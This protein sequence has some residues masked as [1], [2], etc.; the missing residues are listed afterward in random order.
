MWRVLLSIF[1]VLMPLAAVAQNKPIIIT[2]V[3]R[4]PFSIVENGQN[5][6]FS[7]DLWN[8]VASEL[9]RETNFRQADSFTDML[10]QVVDGRV[11]GAI[12]NI[13]ITAERETVM[14]F[15]QPIF[16]SGLQIMLPNDTAGTSVFST[17]FTWDIAFAILIAIAM[18]FGG[19]ML[20]WAFERHKQVYFD[21]DLKDAT[22][23]AFWWAL[24]LVV[25]GG[26]EERMPMS[27]PGRVLSVIM[28][29]ASL[30]LV[31]VFVAKITAAMTVDA[32]QSNVSSLSD[33]DG[34]RVGTI[35]GSTAASFLDQRDI[36]YVGY[37]G[38]TE[39]ITAFEGGTLDA[40]FF[41]GPILSYYATTRGGGKARMVQRVFKPENYGMALPT[42]SELVEQI[43]QA[44]LRI[45]EDGRYSELR[46]KWFG[47][48]N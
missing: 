41:D 47:S 42:N 13:S 22:F 46:R 31:S 20:M 26:F 2:T 17:L 27:R 12:A 18:L 19:G 10:Q 1:L 35:N 37:A 28:V 33:L 23:P 24:N 29:V 7:I 6:G 43:N 40:V 8:M 14:D 15:T 45:R 30:F 11:D 36:Q 39:T 5:T 9:G 3:E 34:R 25:N 32:L 4:E 16:D 21:R 48:A 38:L 44:L